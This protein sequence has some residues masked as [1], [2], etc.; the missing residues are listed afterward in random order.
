MTHVFPWLVGAALV[1]LALAWLG[2]TVSRRGRR[3]DGGVREGAVASVPAPVE[4]TPAAAPSPAPP[5]APR[6]AAPPP[7]PAAPIPPAPPAPPRSA[8]PAPAPAARDGTPP[9]VAGSMAP[10]V[11]GMPVRPSPRPAPPL[12]ER[13]LLLAPADEGDWHEARRVPLGAEQLAAVAGLIAPVTAASG[14][15]SSAATWAVRFAEGAAVHVARGDAVFL[16][17][18]SAANRDAAAGSGAGRRTGW[19][20]SQAAIALA[21]TVLAALAGERYLDALV[22]EAQEIKAGAAALPARLV[23][24]ADGRTRPLAQDLSRFVREAHANYAASIRKTAFRERVADSVLQ[25][26]AL[27]RAIVER[28]DTA[29]QQ[30]DAIARSPRFG[31]AQVDKSL[32]RLRE[33]IDVERL[34]DLVARLLAASHTLALALGEGPAPSADPLA[35]AA[36]SLQAGADQDRD[37]VARLAGCE[38]VAQG[39]PYV[40]RGEFEAHRAELRTLLARFAETAGSGR[41]RIAEAVQRSAADAPGRGPGFADLL[42]RAGPSGAV[43]EARVR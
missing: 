36:A 6:I 42:L 29:R 5:P 30:L 23:A 2:W 1:V 19:L 9:V 18:L 4:A 15:G 16:A 3:D 37:L 20:D 28:A 13:V 12:I 34:E 35:S 10:V 7:P 32:A 22:G 38:R 26:T 41:A 24:E 31:E 39:D 14:R 17:A 43:E 21:G 8:G 33:L 40:G 27:W 11:A 25:T